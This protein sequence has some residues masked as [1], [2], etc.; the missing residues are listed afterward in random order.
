LTKHEGMKLKLP[1]ATDA[2]R[3]FHN[4][5]IE[6]VS[7]AARKVDKP[8]I[9]YGAGS[10]GK[11]AK[12]F[13]GK[14]DIPF[15]YVVDANPDRHAGNNTWNGVSILK[16]EDVRQEDR[17]GCMLAICIATA[18]YTDIIAPLIQQG[19]KDIVP[20]YDIAEAYTDRYPLSNGWFTGIFNN[21]DLKGIEYALQRWG[22][23]ISR[24]H[25]LQ[26]IAWHRL[27]KEL[28][29]DGAPITKDD[30]Y[31]IPQILSSLQE[32]ETFV[33][34]GAHHGEVS[35]RFMDIVRHKFMKVYAIE[36]DKYNVEVLRTRLS[37]DN[38]SEFQKIEIIECALGRKAGRTPFSHGLDYVSQF[39]SMSGESVLVR[40]LDE[41]D[42]PATFVKLHL[43]GWE[44]DALIGAMHTLNKYR[45]LLAVT[46]YHNRNGLWKVPVFL[47]K[48][49]P[50]YIFLLRNHSWMGT[51][52]VVYAMPRASQIIHK[53]E[54]SLYNL[55]KER[56]N[57]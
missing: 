9:L 7:C 33:D 54:G 44:Y 6:D 17:A 10:L 12:E 46:T 56:T 1:N 53:Q 8:L 2:L 48:N 29:F 11:M 3:L 32:D 47:M 14:L 36:P 4:L 18:P 57:E 38:T 23:D 19:W 39:S 25:H 52:C 13:F 16:P 22:D 42:I 40:A 35:L 20:F 31:F 55:S 41:L 50:D 28:L 24:A 26:F 5:I 43:E 30:R 49:L 21:E 37:G 51:G 15:L 27:R 34:G 45:P